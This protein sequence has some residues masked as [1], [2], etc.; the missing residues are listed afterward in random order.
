MERSCPWSGFAR[1]DDIGC[2]PDLCA[3]IVHPA[4][5]WLNLAYFAI[6]AVL[7][8]RYG[9]ADRELRVVVLPWIV[10][11]I[12]IGSAAFHASMIRWLHAM[13]LA[14]IFVLT[15]F[16]LAAY[17]ERAGFV[18]RSLFP[19]CLL[20]LVAPGVAL[21]VLN[22]RAAYVGIALQGA[23]VLWLAWRLPTRGPRRELFRFLALNQVA[24]VA[25]WVDKG[26]VACAG[27]M[28]SN[29]VQPHSF[30]HMFS[31]CSL[32]FVY[33]YERDVERRVAADTRANESPELAGCP[34]RTHRVL[35]HL[36]GTCRMREPSKR[37]SDRR[38]RPN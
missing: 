5:T 21:A 7:I 1:A 36:L 9:A 3:W 13:D 33:R 23:A 6:A 2:E 12:G 11:A 19:R 31:A 30:W 16:L 25:L 27:G 24:A 8:V 37:P 29:V 14:A 20:A 35:R 10:V 22:P 28:L 4:E 32:L 38:R 34:S 17:L 15:G 26:Q 18:A